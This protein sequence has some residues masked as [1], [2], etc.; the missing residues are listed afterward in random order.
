[1]DFEKDSVW[2]FVFEF[3]GHTESNRVYDVHHL[4][5]W[6]P[7]KSI[8]D[9]KFCNEN[10]PYAMSTNE[11]SKECESMFERRTL[12]KKLIFSAA[13]SGAEQVGQDVLLELANI[14][15]LFN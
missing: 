11:E 8:V 12:R 10:M 15:F 7:R 2:F 4:A 1:M 3:D 14:S 9:Y 6:H 5:S 13:P